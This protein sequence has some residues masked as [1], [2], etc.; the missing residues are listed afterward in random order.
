MNYMNKKV[1]FLKNDGKCNFTYITPN[2][3]LTTNKHVSKIA[4]SKTN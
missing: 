3:I 2:N 4:N 1:T